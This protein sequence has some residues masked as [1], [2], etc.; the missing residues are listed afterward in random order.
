M[1]QD[2]VKQLAEKNPDLAVKTAILDGEVVAYDCKNNIILPF[3][4]LSTRKRKV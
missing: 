2:L 4:V 1:I 3:Q